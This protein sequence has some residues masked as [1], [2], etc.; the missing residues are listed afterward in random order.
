MFMS[1]R[2]LLICVAY[3][4]HIGH[5]A[6]CWASLAHNHPSFRLRNVPQKLP[7]GISH[8]AKASF[9]IDQNIVLSLTNN[10]AC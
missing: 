8:W 7:T 3:S 4:L 5:F 10:V 1:V 2:Y 9:L 6:F